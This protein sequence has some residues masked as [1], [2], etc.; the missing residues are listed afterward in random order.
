M[1][2]R[3]LEVLLAARLHR[4]G[5]A[6][7]LI[8]SAFADSIIN[9]TSF[10]D[11]LYANACGED[12]LIGQC[13][14]D[15]AGVTFE[16]APRTTGIFLRS[17]SD[18]AVLPHARIA[19]TLNRDNNALIYI[20]PTIGDIADIRRGL[21]SSKNLVIRLRVT[22]PPGVR[23]LLRAGHQKLLA[24]KAARMIEDAHHEY[25]A[26]TVLTG[27]QGVL[28]GVLATCFLLGAFERQHVSWNGLH[29]FLSLFFLA[30]VVL[31]LVACKNLSGDDPPPLLEISPAE[32]PTYTVMIA[33]Y[34]EADIVPQLVKAMSALN[35]PRSKLQVLFLCEGDDEATLNALKRLDLPPSFDIV[36]ISECAP[37]TK[38]KALNYGLLLSKG[39]FVVVYDAE[40]RPHPDQLLEAFQSFQ[41]ADEKLGCLQAPL[42]IANAH[43]SLVARMFAFEYAAH[44]QSF[45]PWLAHRG[46]V[47][48]LGGSSN[49]FRYDCLTALGGW[50]PHNVTEDAEL[51]TRLARLGYRTGMIT[52]PTIEDAPTE[53]DV[54]YRQRTRWFKG[55]IQ[56]W[57]VQMR[58]PVTLLRQLGLLRF[59][60]YHLLAVGMIVSS[61]LYPFTL[62]F[63]LSSAFCWLSGNGVVV[64]RRDILL[65]DLINIV[66][67]Y[68]SFH[69]LGLRAM[70]GTTMPGRILPWIPLYWLLMSLAAWRALRQLNR[71]PF[72]WE[73]TPH[74]P[75]R[76]IQ[77]NPGQNR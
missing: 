15:V 70:A 67:G 34:Q 54:W 43:E 28:I 71:L 5:L 66:M 19:T 31:R 22:T 14:A 64:V 13:I 39:A 69:R 17:G 20:A 62:L 7:I 38:P 9:R 12:A 32:L 77:E 42:K 61:L 11:E 23:D 72:L 59:L 52:R 6:K 56:T 49:H 51:G 30:C 29:I 24:D 53:V 33:L 1:L 47:L 63:I 3:D 40:D 10:I 48:P 35:W 44:F 58:Q 41:S 4:A 37:R 8:V 18:V 55:W 76:S 57:L 25:S 75:S 2:H 60:V 16:H 46:F 21:P 65:L 36:P 26:K 50:D 73:K 27:Q 45:L 74:R 68:L